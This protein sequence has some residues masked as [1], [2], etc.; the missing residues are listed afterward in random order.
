MSASK[1]F[2]K[3][4]LR[5]H[6][7]WVC[8]GFWVSV[9]VPRV[10]EAV[11]RKDLRNAAP[12]R[13][14]GAGADSARGSATSGFR[15]I[16]VRFRPQLHEALHTLLPAVLPSDFRPSLPCG[17]EPLCGPRVHSR[18]LPGAVRAPV[19]DGHSVDFVLRP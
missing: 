7:I 5:A 10:L 16:V 15:P 12:V 3:G 2:S 14:R 9:F 17:P 19:V 8:F 1:V 18:F 6:G 11:G 13:D 4:D